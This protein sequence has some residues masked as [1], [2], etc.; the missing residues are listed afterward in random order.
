MGLLNDLFAEAHDEVLQEL[1][2]RN[3]IKMWRAPRHMYTSKA[4]PMFVKE[5]NITYEK[6]NTLKRT[7]R[8]GK[9]HW[10]TIARFIAAYLPKLN[11]KLWEGK[12][13]D[14]ELVAWLGKSKMDTLM[15]MVD[16][17]ITTKESRERKRDSNAL[18]RTDLQ[19]KVYNATVVG[20][21]RSSWST[22][23]GKSK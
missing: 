6:F 1:W 20:H 18:A 21:L 15:N 5:N 2:D 9:Q 12:M 17:H 14:D 22:V 19:G 16:S 13:N 11:D 7:P 10:T 3:L 8:Y 4:V 23:K